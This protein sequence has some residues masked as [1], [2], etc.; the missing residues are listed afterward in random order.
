M[1][2]WVCR[3]TLNPS[4]YEIIF[5]LFAKS[6]CR[7]QIIKHTWTETCA[8]AKISSRYQTYWRRENGVDTINLSLDTLEN[9]KKNIACSSSEILGLLHTPH[10]CFRQSKKKLVS[11]YSYYLNTMPSCVWYRGDSRST[12]PLGLVTHFTY[13]PYEIKFMK[14]QQT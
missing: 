14:I 13:S 10:Y 9:L 6:E 4:V 7:F 3:S 8:F 2:E 11:V 12:A 1:N 5:S